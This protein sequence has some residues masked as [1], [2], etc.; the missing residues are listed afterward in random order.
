MGDGVERDHHG[1]EFRGDT[2][3]DS[4]HRRIE[5]GKNRGRTYLVRGG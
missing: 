5:F 4:T 1:K 2:I 3:R